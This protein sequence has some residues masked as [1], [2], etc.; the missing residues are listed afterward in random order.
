[1]H[2]SGVVALGDYRAERHRLRGIITG[3]IAKAGY[4]RRWPDWSPISAIR[5]IS[6]VGCLL[7]TLQTV[8]PDI[9]RAGEGNYEKIRNRHHDAVSVAGAGNGP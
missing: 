6:C 7:K 9:R 5:R 1:M 4:R 2:G 8:R 3:T